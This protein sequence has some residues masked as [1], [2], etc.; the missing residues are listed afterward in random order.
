M[1]AIA[2]SVSEN[3]FCI[4]S[5]FNIFDEFSDRFAGF[6]APTFRAEGVAYIVANTVSR[7]GILVFYR[8]LDL[9]F[10]ISI[11]PPGGT[12]A[13]RDGKNETPFR[14]EG[15]SFVKRLFQRIVIVLVG[16]FPEFDCLD[17]KR[18]QFYICIHKPSDSGSE[19]RVVIVS[20]CAV[21]I[22]DWRVERFADF[23]KRSPFLIDDF[24]RIIRHIGKVF[25]DAGKK[26]DGN[27]T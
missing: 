15:E 1:S 21:V 22:E 5:A 17:A 24:N 27:T 19:I 10:R 8:V 9:L 25:A 16:P 23:E 7:R 18:K 4:R 14:S 13:K 12:M 11:M 2:D 20:V 26:T 6:F 3:V